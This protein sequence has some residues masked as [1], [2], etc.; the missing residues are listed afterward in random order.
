MYNKMKISFP[1]HSKRICFV[2]TLE[3]INNI[4]KFDY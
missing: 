2:Y 1:V 3:I 4:L